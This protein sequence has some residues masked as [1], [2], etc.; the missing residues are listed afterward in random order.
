MLVENACLASTI[1]LQVSAS[2][3]ASLRLGICWLAY[4]LL[5]MHL[6]TLQKHPYS[7]ALDS[8]IIWLE[9]SL[10]E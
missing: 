3:R 1:S 6:A 4:K 2:E 9:P 5:A 8:V 7:T 10:T